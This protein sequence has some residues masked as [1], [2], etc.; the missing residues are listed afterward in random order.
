MD[1]LVQKRLCQRK[2]RR[3]MTTLQNELHVHGWAS[4]HDQMGW[5]YSP[6]SAWQYYTA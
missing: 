5:P 3:L 4:D 6:D 1:S 2:L